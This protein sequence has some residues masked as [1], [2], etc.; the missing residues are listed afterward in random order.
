M[1]MDTVPMDLGGK[2]FNERAPV[3]ESQTTY[4]GGVIGK[5]IVHVDCNSRVVGDTD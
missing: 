2:R 5:V 3:D 4:R 1:L